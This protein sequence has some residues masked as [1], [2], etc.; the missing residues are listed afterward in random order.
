MHTISL[1]FSH[2]VCMSLLVFIMCIS[3]I[4]TLPPKTPLQHHGQ[5]YLDGQKNKKNSCTPDTNCTNHLHLIQGSINSPHWV[6]REGHSQMKM[7]PAVA[8]I[9]VYSSHHHCF[10]AVYSP[11]PWHNSRALNILLAFYHIFTPYKQSMRSWP[12]LESPHLSR[13]LSL[14]G[15]LSEVS[16]LVKSQGIT[17]SHVLMKD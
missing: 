3:V 4:V 6:R 15:E 5:W 8:D 2:C 17:N 1:L 16:D 12:L 13:C 9:L 11:W 7:V 10:L 14:G